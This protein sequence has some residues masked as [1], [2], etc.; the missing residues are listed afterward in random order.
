LLQ[1]GRLY[2]ERWST[3]NMSMRGGWR[4]LCGG[5][6]EM[7]KE[8]VAGFANHVRYKVGDGSKVLFW[9]DVWCGKQPLKALFSELFTI[10]CG[11]DAWVSKNM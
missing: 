4:T 1:G 6:I 5:S 3:L 8:G 7:Y 2:G 10:A 9:H 11:K